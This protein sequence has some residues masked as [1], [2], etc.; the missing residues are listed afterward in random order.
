MSPPYSFVRSEL[1]VMQATYTNE[2]F[3]DVVAKLI[4]KKD[5]QI[6]LLTTKMNNLVS[7]D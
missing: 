3:L 6:E 5:E 2:E 7:E 1:R 4:E